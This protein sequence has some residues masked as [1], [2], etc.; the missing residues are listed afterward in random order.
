ME[1]SVEKVAEKVGEIADKKDK[2]TAVT[3]L[4]KGL[5]VLKSSNEKPIAEDGKLG[6]ETRSI[7]KN[8]LMEKGEEEVV[9]SL[10]DEQ[11]TNEQNKEKIEQQEKK[12]KKNNK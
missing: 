9:N 12:N 10:K 5:N 6:P 2:K 7:L 11:E 8:T 4:Q 3:E 1:K